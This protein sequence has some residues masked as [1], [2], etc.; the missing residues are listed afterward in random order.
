[1]LTQVKIQGEKDWLFQ[2]EKTRDHYGEDN[3]EIYY[4]SGEPVISS[5]MSIW[6]NEQQLKELIYKA[7]ESLRQIERWEGKTNEI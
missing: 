2:V 7:R 3:F 1:M 5:Q 4:Q 6:L